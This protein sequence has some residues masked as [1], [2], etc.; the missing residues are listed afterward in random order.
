MGRISK[1]S[2]FV[3][4]GV[5]FLT[6]IPIFLFL[7]RLL[8]SASAIEVKQTGRIVLSQEATTLM[9]VE[10]FVR[11]ED[12]V[13][14]VPDYKDGN[15]KLYDEKG[16]LITV[17]GRRGPG[18]MEF[19]SPRGSDYQSKT[20]AVSDFSK[21]RIYIFK[22]TGRTNFEKITEFVYPVLDKF[23]PRLANGRIYISGY[24]PVSD[25]E[26]YS[27]F[28][29]DL[30]TGELEYIL[31]N[32][33]KYGFSSFGQ[34]DSKKNSV[35][36]LGGA[37]FCD[38]LEDSIYFVWEGDLKILKI[39]GSTKKWESFGYKTKNYRQ[40]KVTTALEMAISVLSLEG[41]DTE[42]A[43]MS[44]VNAIFADKGFVG[45]VFQNYDSKSS[46]W[47]MFLQ[48]Y[49]P[50][51]EFITETPLQDAVTYIDFRAGNSFYDRESHTLY[52]LSIRYD[53]KTNLDRY[54]IISYKIE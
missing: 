44:F 15:F 40:P 20:L 4:P 16:N 31:P 27:L 52:Y 30:Q 37:G 22:R 17:W 1:S 3:L 12:G 53:E 41:M 13:F 32:W 33:T 14:I 21:Q 38:V 54:E 46:L 6:V 7:P 34:Y 26:A 23:N 28:S 45:V 11:T 48:L 35:L 5:I 49:T 42:F 47:K 24:A 2:N 25:K 10:S 39:D 43:K 50:S 18:P 19:L 51:G 29:R 9:A 8:L 36:S